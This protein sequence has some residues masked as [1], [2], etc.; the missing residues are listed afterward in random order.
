R[1]QQIAKLRE[2]AQAALKKQQSGKNVTEPEGLEAPQSEAIKLYSLALEMALGRPIWEPQQL[3][4]EEVASIYTS[5]AHAYAAIRAWADA[6]TD[7]RL[8]LEAK[9]QGNPGAY[10]V[11]CDSL[12]EMGRVNEAAQL[13]RRGINQEEA[14]MGL[15]RQQIAQ[16]Q[17]QNHPGLGQARGSLGAL[18]KELEG[19]KEMA[20]GMGLL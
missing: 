19:L 12:R 16:M 7:C 8:S 13:L 5:R 10:R 15:L 14:T 1:S 20:R 18:E 11:G 3:L 17:A 2:S 9:P 4:R 6:Y